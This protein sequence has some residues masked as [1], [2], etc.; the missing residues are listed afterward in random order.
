MADSEELRGW[1]D[2]LLVDPPAR[3]VAAQEVAR[4]LLAGLGDPQNRFPAVHLVGTAGKGTVAALLTDRLTGAGVGVVTHMSPHVHDLRE[5][6]LVDG[7]L[8]AWPDVLDAAA[9][10]VDA[11]NGLQQA[12]GARPTYFAATAAIAWE[13]GR[14]SG[15]EIA[16]IEAGIGGRHDATNVMARADVLTVITAIGVD[17]TDALGPTVEAIAAEKAAVMAGRSDAVVG[18]QPDPGAA[19]VIEAVARA[20][21]CRLHRVGATQDWI[22]AA[23]MTVETAAPLLEARLGRDLPPA[24]ISL[25]PGRMERRQIGDRMVILDGAHNPLKLEAL[26]RAMAGGVRPAAVVAAVGAGKD[27]SGCA[28]VLA[29]MGRLVVATD[30]G[31][32]GRP[33]PRSHPAADLAAAVSAAGGQAAAARE[34]RDAA[35]RAVGGSAPGDTIV[36]TGSFLHLAAAVDAIALA[37][38]P[39]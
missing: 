1:L 8:P 35:V 30:F 28:E 6:F 32:R 36:V 33:G 25:P 13:L 38:T 27:L 2:G 9:A 26:Q 5:R 39:R 15:A 19:A 11:A 24:A 31:D 12:T 21:R 37:L 34:V 18:P 16:V 3:G 29:R 7:S 23:A 20:E 4:R 10:V 14:R 22:E 17:H